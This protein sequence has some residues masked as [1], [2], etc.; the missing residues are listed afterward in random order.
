ME[1]TATR[2]F[3]IDPGDTAEIVLLAR[4]QFII[5]ALAIEGD[6]MVFLEVKALQQLLIII[7]KYGQDIENA[8]S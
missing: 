5:E 3:K 2:L 1:E 6:I 8:S 4:T 7:D